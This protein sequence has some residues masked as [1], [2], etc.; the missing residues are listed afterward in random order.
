MAY[1]HQVASP[2]GERSALRHEALFKEAPQRDRQFARNRNDHDASDTPALPRC[3]L[4]KPASDRTL[5]LVLQPE[6]S[7][8]DY[9][10]A[11]VA[12]PGSRDALRS[13]HVSAVMRTRC[14]TE[15]AGHLPPVGELAIVDL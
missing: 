10:P 12:S 1:A 6:P 4:H 8:L 3:S 15:K 14:K 9:G 13:F 7:R 2:A 11:H 5:W